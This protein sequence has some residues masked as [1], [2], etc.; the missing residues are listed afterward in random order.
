M[1]FEIHK[2]TN[3]NR[4]SGK[5]QTRNGIIFHV[6]IHSETQEEIYV[7]FTIEKILKSSVSLR[8]PKTLNVQQEFR[9]N[10][11]SMS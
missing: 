4:N 3:N 5:T 6:K 7:E 10:T 8:C 1:S 11:V 9:L 2:I